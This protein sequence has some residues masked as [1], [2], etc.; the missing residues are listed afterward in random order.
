M[1]NTNDTNVTSWSI[2]PVHTTIGFSVRH[3][4]VANVRGEFQRVTGKVL[5][6]A[7][8]PAATE[9]QAEVPADSVSTREPQRDAHLRSPDFFDVERHPKLSF[10]STGVRLGGGGGGTGLELV[11]DLMIRGTTRQV[12]LSVTE[13]S[14]EQRDHNGRTRMGASATGKIKRSEFGITYNKV[15]EATRVAVGDEVT[16]LLDLALLKDEAV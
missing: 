1:N 3:M 6:D 8:R 13:V 4:M 11:G 14:G 10:R 7:K 15:L 16:L 5:Y 2:D 9:V 12:T